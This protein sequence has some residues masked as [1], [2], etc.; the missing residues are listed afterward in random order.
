MGDG[1]YSYL[2]SFKFKIFYSEY[3]GCRWFYRFSIFWERGVIDEVM[4][5]LRIL[6]SH[7][8]IIPILRYVLGNKE[9]IS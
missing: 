2:N 1:S 3:D 4:E 8:I 6:A 7:E 5:G 9:S